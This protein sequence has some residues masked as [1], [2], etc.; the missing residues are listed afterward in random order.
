MPVRS[1]LP[2]Q[3]PEPLAQQL[4]QA[5]ADPADPGAERS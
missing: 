1:Q 5:T 2:L 4:K 3:L